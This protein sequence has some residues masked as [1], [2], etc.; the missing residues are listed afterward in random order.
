M[1]R[2]AS[3]PED[4]HIPAIRLACQLPPRSSS[5]P[6]DHP[7]L[8]CG[9]L[10][11]LVENPARNCAIATLQGAP[12]SPADTP[13][14]AKL[15]KPGSRPTKKAVSSGETHRT[16]RLLNCTSADRRSKPPVVES[17]PPPQQAGDQGSG[18]LLGGDFGRFGGSRPRLLAPQ[19]ENPLR[20][21]L[22]VPDQT[23]L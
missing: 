21:W 2:S 7:T 1:S 15:W 4:H 17:L 23:K 14:S 6:I 10:G 20:N 19:I 5:R 11:L 18:G 16:R 8:Q 3:Q 13:L 22:D 9:F 12:V